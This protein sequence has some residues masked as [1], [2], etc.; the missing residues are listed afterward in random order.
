MNRHG[1]QACSGGF[2]LVELLVALTIMGLVSGLLLNS[3]QFSLHTV[4]SV[5]SQLDAVES[6]HQS[7]RALRRQLSLAR[8]V[9]MRDS[10]DSRRLEFSADLKQ[11]DFIAPVPG[12]AAGGGLY[13]VSLRVEDDPRPDGMD[14]RLVMSYQMYLD[15][16]QRSTYSTDRR[17]VVLLDHFSRA[18]FNFL[19]TMRPGGG[20]WS[21][22]W[23]HNDRLPG[24]IRLS[25]DVADGAPPG[26]GDLIVEIKSTMPSG[27]GRS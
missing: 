11:V 20:D 8:P 27:L 7:Q 3:I 6:M 24:L 15:R 13:R 4:D 14:G 12:L 16:F 9:L 19:D 23:P 21:S 1:R 22:D 2:T 5:E 25:I 26:A 10:E 18:Q 17:E